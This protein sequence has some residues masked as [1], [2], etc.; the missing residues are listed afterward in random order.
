MCAQD[1]PVY[2]RTW[3]LAESRS[4]A[5]QTVSLSAEKLIALPQ[6]ENGLLLEVKN[7]LVREA[8]RAGQDP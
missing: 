7:L 3:A 8:F 2:G 6:K 1:S 4:Q 5:E